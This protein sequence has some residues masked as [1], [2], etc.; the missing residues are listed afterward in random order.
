MVKVEEIRDKEYRSSSPYG[1]SEYSSSSDSVASTSSSLSAASS[2]EQETLGERLAA[3]VDIVPP[4][5]RQSIKS[6]VSNAASIAKRV[7][8]I[9]GNII[10]VVTT[11]AL[12]V[13]LPLALALEDEAK[14]VQQEKEMLAQQQGA[15]GMLSPYGQPGQPG[16]PGQ[17][18]S[19]GLV[20]PGF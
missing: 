6:K 1:S 20:P 15:Q 19:S 18:S 3:L 10:W 12:L 17:S 7:G 11:S 14:I 16:Q 8:K 5:T 9:G 2:P 4:T 13:G